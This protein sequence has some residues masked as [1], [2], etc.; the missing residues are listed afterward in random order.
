MERDREPAQFDDSPR[1][2][3][4]RWWFVRFAFSFI[5]LGAVAAYEG[6]R[7]EKRGDDGRATVLFVAAAGGVALG[8]TGVRMRHRGR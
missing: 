4:A 8:L 7:A 6:W 2:W 1:R 5:V 3:S